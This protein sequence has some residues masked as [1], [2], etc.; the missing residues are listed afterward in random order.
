MSD[1][2]HAASLKTVVRVKDS[3]VVDSYMQKFQLSRRQTNNNHT[4]TRY[5]GDSPPCYRDSLHAGARL[6]SAVPHQVEP[7][8]CLV[9]Y[10]GPFGFLRLTFSPHEKFRRI[11]AKSVSQDIWQ[12]TS[13]RHRRQRQTVIIWTRDEEV[14]PATTRVLPLTDSNESDLSS[15]DTRVRTHRRLR[16]RAREPAAGPLYSVDIDEDAMKPATA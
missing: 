4:Y 6:Q 12:Y 14:E 16:R 13:G 10:E 11:G 8:I 7:A 3:V 1:N 9:D 2:A 5:K 15:I